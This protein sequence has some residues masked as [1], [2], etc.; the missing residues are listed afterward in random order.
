MCNRSLASPH[1]LQTKRMKSLESPPTVEPPPPRPPLRIAHL[2][3]WTACTALYLG[4]LR[5]TILPITTEPNV[6]NLGSSVPVATLMVFASVG[7]GAGLAGLVLWFAYHRRGI[8]FP[9]H[10]GEYFIPMRGISA[11]IQSLQ[12]AITPSFLSEPDSIGWIIFSLSALW[13]VEI[14]APFLAAR[15]LSVRPWPTFFF[16]RGLLSF[17]PYLGQAASLVPL[18]LVICLDHRRARQY[19]WTHWLGV[20]L[21]LWWN[22]LF[23]LLLLRLILV[24]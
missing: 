22:A 13:A 7:S 16:L 18:I 21:E 10:P 19:P 2:L 12:F 1:D 6:A 14:M 4:V 24:A 23:A 9:V 17:C 3:I 5:G 11:V 15:W 20:A 8:R